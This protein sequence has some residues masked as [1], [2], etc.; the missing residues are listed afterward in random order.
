MP[1]RII[2]ERG[3]IPENSAKPSAWLLAWASQQVCDV[4]HE[5]DFRSKVASQTDN[6]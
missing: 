5:N 2:P 3:Q 6:F 4:L 1:D